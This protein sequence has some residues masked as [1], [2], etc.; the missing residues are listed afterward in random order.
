[1]TTG[2]LRGRASQGLCSCLGASISQ[3]Q[4]WGHKCGLDPQSAPTGKEQETFLTS[5][6]CP[7]SPPQPFLSF[8]FSLIPRSWTQPSPLESGLPPCTSWSLA[9]AGLS[10]TV[11]CSGFFCFTHQYSCLTTRGSLAEKPQALPGSTSFQLCSPVQVAWFSKPVSL[12]EKG[13][14]S[15]TPGGGLASTM[16]TCAWCCPSVTQHELLQSLSLVSEAHLMAELRITLPCW[17]GLWIR[18]VWYPV[19]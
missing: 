13:E 11:F 18:W 9:A 2:L 7:L 5:L 1:M 16:E 17:P 10:D 15:C 6:P 3:V 19:T 14:L 4:G 8:P 12:P